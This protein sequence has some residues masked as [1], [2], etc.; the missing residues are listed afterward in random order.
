MTEIPKGFGDVHPLFEKPPE[1]PEHK[2]LFDKFVTETLQGFPVLDDLFSCFPELY[3]QPVGNYEDERFIKITVDHSSLLAKQVD[4]LGGDLCNEN[5]TFSIQTD[6]SLLRITE[7]SPTID[8]HKIESCYIN[9]NLGTGA[10]RRFCE[11]ITD[12]PWEDVEG[13]LPFLEINDE[14]RQEIDSL[15][16][17]FR[18]R[19]FIAN[20]AL[21]RSKSIGDIS[22]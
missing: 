19:Y 17:N 11:Y 1:L 3:I 8:P 13:I 14:E 10:A 6:G 2:R 15:H 21:A 16:H 9:A 4:W 20:A 5:I 7:L 12:K 18:R 22:D